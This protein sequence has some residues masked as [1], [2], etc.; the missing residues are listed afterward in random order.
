MT[1][2]RAVWQTYSHWSGTKGLISFII[3]FKCIDLNTTPYIG[4]IGHETCSIKLLLLTKQSSSVY[5]KEEFKLIQNI[6]KWYKKIQF[7]LFLFGKSWKLVS[8]FFQIHIV[9]YVFVRASQRNKEEV[10]IV[11]NK[12]FKF[13]EIFLCFKMFI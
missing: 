12:I 10:M 8:F 6:R 2:V 5:L 1:W 9:K 7:N 11:C 4:S 13:F 3:I